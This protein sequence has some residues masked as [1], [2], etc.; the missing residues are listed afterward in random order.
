[1]ITSQPKLSGPTEGGVSLRI[2][3]DDRLDAQGHI[4]TATGSVVNV[5][6]NGGDAELYGFELESVLRPTSGRTFN[7]GLGYTHNEFVR[8]AGGVVGVTYD[9]KLPHVPEWTAS[10]DGQFELPTSI[11]DW[12]FRADASYRSDQSS[13]S[14][15]QRR[16][17][18]VTRSSMRASRSN[19]LLC[20]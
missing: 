15:T 19:R 18:K 20:H 10:L 11:G 2:G 6:Q 13:R 8:L 5:T 17:K 7:L 1:M 9:T 14:P 16:W 4:N 3:E 12:I